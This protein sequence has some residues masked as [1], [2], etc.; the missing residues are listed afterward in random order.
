MASLTLICW[1][2]QKMNNV[3][4]LGSGGRIGRILDCMLYY[5]MHSVFEWK[6]SA[7]TDDFVIFIL[8]PRDNSN[9]AT[10]VSL[11]TEQT[12]DSLPTVTWNYHGC[13]GSR[14]M[15]ESIIYGYS[16]GMKP[17]Q[18]RELDISEDMG[19]LLDLNWISAQEQYETH[20]QNIS[21]LRNRELL[22][23]PKDSSAAVQKAKT[24]NYQDPALRGKE[25]ESYR[26]PLLFTFR[27]FRRDDKKVAVFH[28]P[29][30]SNMTK[31][32]WDVY[33]KRI[34]REMPHVVMGDFN[35]AWDPQITGYIAVTTD[36]GG[37]THKKDES[38]SKSRWDKIY[39][40]KTLS[41]T[42]F[43]ALTFSGSTLSDHAAM[44]LTLVDANSGGLRV[45][46]A[47]N[48]TQLIGTQDQEVKSDTPDAAQDSTGSSSTSSSSSSSTSSKGALGSSNLVNSKSSSS[49]DM[50]TGAS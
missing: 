47:Y 37:T 1:N 45:E 31:D 19:Q 16:R 27:S 9:T 10:L 5:A 25:A 15:K 38:Q 23:A 34:R 46:S 40:N 4:A 35:V 44:M 26:H 42:A 43:P 14:N 18:I 24:E 12:R 11:L 48:F 39:L 20:K 7:F 28:A 13:G 50:D 41:A 17:R 33:H 22:K 36:L 21:G 2:I 29:G 3:K 49:S 6:T 30:P 32:I 8:E